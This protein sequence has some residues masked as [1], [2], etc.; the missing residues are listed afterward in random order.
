MELALQLADKIWLMDKGGGIATGTPE[1]L[2]LVKDGPGER[3]RF[4]DMAI[5]QLRPSYYYTLQ[6][7]NNALKQ[8]F[9]HMH[10]KK[11]Y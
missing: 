10:L 2:S 8:R 4:L 7:Y 3:R 5:S 1:D 6:Q 9:N 11:K